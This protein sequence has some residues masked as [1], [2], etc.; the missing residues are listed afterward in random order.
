QLVALGGRGG[1]LLL[2]NAKLLLHAREPLELLRRRLPV[3]LAPSAQVVDLRNEPA[4]ALVGSEQ[5]VEGARRALPRQRGAEALRVGARG[6]EVD[7]ACESRNASITAATPSSAAGGQI[8]S[9]TALTRSCAFSTA[10]PKPA[11]ST[12]S[13]SFSPS[14]NAIVCSRVKPIRSRRN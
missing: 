2:A 8:Q 4:P 6:S 9:A 1:E 7:H 3:E 13:T 12:R 10:I 5:R 11:H 14:P